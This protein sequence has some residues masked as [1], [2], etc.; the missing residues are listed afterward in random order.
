MKIDPKTPITVEILSA[1]I[2]ELKTVY[3]K[4]ELIARQKENNILAALLL[5]QVDA[6]VNLQ[7]SIKNA[8]V[9]QQTKKKEI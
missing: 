7:T 9:D 1:A 8:I 3:Q 5:H 4:Q 6:F 2:E